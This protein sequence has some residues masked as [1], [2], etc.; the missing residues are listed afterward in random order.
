MARISKRMKQIQDSFDTEKF[1]TVG[2][3][4]DILLNTSKVNFDETVDIAIRLNVDTK[5]ADQN[6]RGVL[7]LPNGTGKTYKVAVFAKSDKHKEAK[8]AG[9]DFVGESDL[10][11]TV[12]AGK[13]GFDKCVATPDMMPLLGKVAKILGP[14][15][16]MPNPKLGTVTTNIADTV[17]KIKAGQIEYRCEKNG[18][19]HAGVGKISFGREKIVQNVNSFIDAVVKNKPASV[20]GVFVKSISISS[21][22]GVGIKISL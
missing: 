2:E 15:G 10:I 14:K 16:L 3:A 22:M 21:T 13:I 12:S 5:L 20:K 1:Y 7:S 18:I 8:E 9:A 11:A 6:I 4:V 19:I 17:K